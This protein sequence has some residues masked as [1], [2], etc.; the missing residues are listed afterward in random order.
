LAEIQAWIRD[1]E[2]D[3]LT[4]AEKQEILGQKLQQIDRQIEELNQMKNYL[5]NKIATLS[6]G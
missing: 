2:S 4:V 6:S 5:Q 1:F 3:Q